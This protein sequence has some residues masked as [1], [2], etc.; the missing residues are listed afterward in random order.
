MGFNHSLGATVKKLL[1]ESSLGM[2]FTRVSPKA[3][4]LAGTFKLS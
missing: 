2:L 3:L 1:A 4:A